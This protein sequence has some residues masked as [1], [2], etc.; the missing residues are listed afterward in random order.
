MGVSI[1]SLGVLL[2]RARVRNG[3]HRIAWEAGMA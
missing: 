2:D 3:I 1:V